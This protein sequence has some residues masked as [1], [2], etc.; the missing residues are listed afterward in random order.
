VSARSDGTVVAVGYT[1][2][3]YQLIYQNAA[4]APKAA[5][6]AAAPNTTLLAP[7]DA[8]AVDQLLAATGPADPPL[9]LAGHDVRA[10]KR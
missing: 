4:S 6:P 10:H 2:A 9:A 1:A 7:L 5:T 3:N 8:A